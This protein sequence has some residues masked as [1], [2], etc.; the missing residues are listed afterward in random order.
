[1]RSCCANWTYRD[2]S[3]T[4]SGVGSKRGPV[5]RIKLAI[6]LAFLPG[7]I[8]QS[9]HV[10]PQPDKNGVYRVVPGIVAPQLE[11]SVAAKYPDDPT[12]T[13]RNYGCTLTVVIGENGTPTSITPLN[14]DSNPFIESAVEAVR[15]SSFTA[16]T[17]AGKPVPVQLMIAVP[18]DK[19]GKPA[20]PQ[21]LRLGFRTVPVP[22]Y[23]PEAT[24]T[25]DAR[26]KKLEG[27]VL[28][29]VIVNEKGIPTDV[30][31]IRSLDP[32]LDQNAIK[33]VRQYRFEP[34]KIDGVSFPV[35]MSIEV[36]FRLH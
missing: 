8:L 2:R 30:N 3:T 1:M 27:V 19:K 29:S 6:A 33:A 7:Q 26:R 18:F 36:N 17:L 10:Q 4:Y 25:D 31:V 21:I 24:Y 12:L 11:L 9:Q 34:L 15:Q 35:R 16:G 22:V 20:L 14:T 5:Q 23:T 13:K 32:G 28:T